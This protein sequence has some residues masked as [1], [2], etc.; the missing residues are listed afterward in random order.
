MLSVRGPETCGRYEQA[1]NLVPVQ[2][3]IL[4]T[5]RL[6]TGLA[7]IFEDRC[8]N[9]GFFFFGEI[10]SLVENLSLPGPYFRLFL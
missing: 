2:A 6:R 10:I 8:P 1:N 7:T 3:H 5:F 9:S 4:G